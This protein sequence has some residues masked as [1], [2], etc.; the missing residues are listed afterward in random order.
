M[1]YCDDE[2]SALQARNKKLVTLLKGVN[3]SHDALEARARKAVMKLNQ[4]RMA[5][6]VDVVRLKREL[7][8]SRTE[9][10][11]AESDYQEIID[12]CWPAWACGLLCLVSGA[13]GLV[14]G[15]LI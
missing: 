14:V 11:T 6:T 15:V 8:L 7:N 3:D 1:P 4:D 13:A 5:L 12:S 10:D 2:L 9:L